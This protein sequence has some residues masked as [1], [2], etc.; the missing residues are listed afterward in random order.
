MDFRNL[1]STFVRVLIAALAMGGAA[2]LASSSLGGVR[3]APKVL[4]LLQ[5]AAGLLG[6][7]LIYG[8]AAKALRITEMGDFI[9]AF[10]RK[11]RKGENHG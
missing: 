7:L 3:A 10:I 5:V 2:W 8:A 9:Q 6:G 4:A 1:S 11:T